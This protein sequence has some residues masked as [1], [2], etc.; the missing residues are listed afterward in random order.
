MTK[1]KLSSFTR[2]HLLK[3]QM[4]DYK[5]LKFHWI[6]ET[7]VLIRWSYVYMRNNG[8]LH[9]AS[10]KLEKLK[11]RYPLA[12]PKSIITWLDCSS[13]QALCYWYL[14]LD[15]SQRILIRSGLVADWLGLVWI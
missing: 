8:K 10:V 5:I 3:Q 1:K 13:T 12:K 4:I 15:W 11:E 6:L 7:N 2:P 9:E 14:G